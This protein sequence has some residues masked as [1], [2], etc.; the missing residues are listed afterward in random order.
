LI[1]SGLNIVEIASRLGHSVQVCQSVYLHLIEDK[2]P[3]DT[4]REDGFLKG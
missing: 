1:Y 2:K 4:S 3:F